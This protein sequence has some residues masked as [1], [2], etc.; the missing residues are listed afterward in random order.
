MNSNLE[1]FLNHTPKEWEELKSKHTNITKFILNSVNRF[2]LPHIEQP[3]CEPC[4]G[5]KIKKHF[6]LNIDTKY[7]SHLQCMARK[8]GI[9]VSQL[10]DDLIVKP[11]LPHPLDPL[12]AAANSQ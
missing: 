4:E 6:T 1:V 3:I 8:K 5:E 2:L 10:I 12:K 11:A 9:T 7:I